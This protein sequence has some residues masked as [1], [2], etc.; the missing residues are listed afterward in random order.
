MRIGTHRVRWRLAASLLVLT[1]P[2]QASTQ[3]LRET[4]LRAPERACTIALTHA[5][6][7]GSPTDDVSPTPFEVGV[8]RDQRDRY[9]VTP[10]SDL[11]SFA[12][13]D[14]SGRLLQVIGR[15]GAGPGEFGFIMRL[16]VFG[17]DSLIAL[18]VGN[19]RMTVLS[20]GYQPVRS[21]P[22]PGRFTRAFSLG[23]GRWLVN[24]TARAASAAG[25][26][27]HVLGPRGEIERSFGSMHAQV[28]RDRP[29][30]DLRRIAVGDS[31]TIWLARL[32]QYLLEE[33]SSAGSLVRSLRRHADWFPPRDY[34][35]RQEPTA[36]PDP[37]LL[38]V[39]RD[40]TGYLWV[41]ARV[42]SPAFR[43]P[44]QAP[45]RREH[46]MPPLEWQDA[47]HDVI[48][49][50]IDPATARVLASRRLPQYLIGHVEADRVFGLRALPNGDTRVEIWRASLTGSEGQTC[51]KPL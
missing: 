47:N 35:R 27:L 7:L 25:L 2:S 21:F 31:G 38:D 30:A 18:D 51:P 20:P 9:Y 10:T 34:G 15:Q 26:P 45:G 33:W 11:S 50:V 29:Q 43:A 8:V 37:L 49:E 39:W 16:E 22:M 6:T 3:S 42:A 36:R 13:Y 40:Q 46:P 14:G 24:G 41:L 48:I 23:S 32:D 44:P 17:G 5:V 12:A 19:S 1:L 28:R 4:S